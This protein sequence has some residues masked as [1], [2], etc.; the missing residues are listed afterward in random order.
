VR[1]VVGDR[2]HI[3]AQRRRQ[4]GDALRPLDPVHRL[5]Q[6][7]LVEVVAGLLPQL[8]RDG[9]PR[10]LRAFDVTAGLHQQPALA[11][12]VHE[13]VRAPVELAQD[14]RA[15]RQVVLARSGV[16]VRHP[17]SLTDSARTRA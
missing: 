15:G 14:Q 11:V 9:R 1:V 16:E 8:V 4:H 17:L 10:V 3:H 5:E 2:V 7:Q 13:H 6:E 12:A